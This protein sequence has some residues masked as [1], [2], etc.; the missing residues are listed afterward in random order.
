MTF[1]VSHVLNKNAL[2][3]SNMC[4]LSQE[5]GKVILEDLQEANKMEV[6]KVFIFVASFQ[7]LCLIIFTSM[8]DVVRS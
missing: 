1:T 6:R 2:S 3:K 8:I 7:N 5:G 4:N